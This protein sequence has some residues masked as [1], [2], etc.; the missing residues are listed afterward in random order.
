MG[1]RSRCSVD[2]GIIALAVKRKGLFSCSMFMSER[3][4]L[5]A[6]FVEIL[7]VGKPIELTLSQN[8]AEVH[9]P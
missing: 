8:D 9:K 4:A 5:P 3:S 7:Y 1:T 2:T 6:W